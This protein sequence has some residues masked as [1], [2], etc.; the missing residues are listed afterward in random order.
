MSVA[1]VHR[2]WHAGNHD[3]FYTANAGEIGTTT[4]G[5]AGNHGYV[6]END[7]FALFSQPHPGLV[8]VYRY[9]HAEWHNHFYTANGAEIGGINPGQPANY[10]YA[11]EGI[12]GYINAHEFPGSVPIYRYY[13]EQNRDHFYTTKA[14]EIGTTNV[15]QV[16]NHGYKFEAILGYGY[17][18]DHHIAI[19]H[20]YWHEG[21]HDHFYTTNGGEIG[22][23]EKGHVGNHGYKS[24]GPAFL[25]FT[26]QLHGTVPVYRY[27]KEDGH[28][29]F[30]SANPAEIGATNVG[31][32]GNF[33]YKCEGV[34]GY[35]AAHDFAGSTPIYRYWNEQTKDHFF[36]SDAAEIGATQVGQVGNHG[37][38]CEGVLGY[39]PHQ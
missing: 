37:Y 3:H 39:V 38:K 26:Q 24:E 1:I 27:W 23:T 20:R 15:G 19:V 4:P 30:Y 12:L 34:L 25:I 8:P 21:N 22:T 2:Y 33:G 10:G 5:Q 28:D 11:Y 31:Q 17:P 16:G 29:H 9:W 36:T 14:E 13:H 6:F 18:V 32:V 7:S 35:V